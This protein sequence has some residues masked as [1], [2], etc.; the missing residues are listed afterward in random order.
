MAS[1]ADKIAIITGGASGIGAA[2]ADLFVA[3]GAR[4]VIGDVH[5]AA[6][7]ALAARLGAGAF[8]CPLDVTVA[9]DWQRLVASTLSRFGTIDVL[10]NNAGICA[11][12][13]IAQETKAGFERTLEVNVIG[14]FLGIQAV[15]PAMIAAGRGAIVNL[16]ST[17]GMRGTP[18]LTAYVASKWG[19]RGLTKAAAVEL[20]GYGIRVNS[21]HPGVINTPLSNPSGVSSAA[22]NTDR[23]FE[24]AL[25]AQ[26]I[27]RIGEVSEVARVIVFLASDAATYVTGAEV[28]V[29]GG[30]LAGAKTIK[31][32][33]S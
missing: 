3:E 21:V 9:D 10:V 15:M 8:F 24:R 17:E 31:F 13:L 33:N 20:G 7:E 6:G 12:N 29:D 2:T 18:A 1:L 32:T 5:T 30:M 25:A 14:A 19:V 4:V 26:P 23:R 28:A 22:M 27:G 16:S 11:P